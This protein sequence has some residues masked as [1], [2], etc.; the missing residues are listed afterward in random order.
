VRVEFLDGVIFT[1][2]PLLT[3]TRPLRPPPPVR[4]VRAP[5]YHASQVLNRWVGR[6]RSYGIE[7]FSPLL[8]VAAALCF[9]VGCAGCAT[10]MG[11]LAATV[12]V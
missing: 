5:R 12:V 11:T 6:I 2:K 7:N 8:N 1:A 10:P 3:L 9:A 4:V